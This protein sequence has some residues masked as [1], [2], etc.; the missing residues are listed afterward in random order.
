[1]NEKA[2]F[3][4]CEKRHAMG[5]RVPPPQYCQATYFSDC[6]TDYCEIW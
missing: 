5:D 2:Y 1:M 4:I 3:E 6:A